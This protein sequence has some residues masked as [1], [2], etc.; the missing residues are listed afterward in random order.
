MKVCAF[1]SKKKCAVLVNGNCEKCSFCKTRRELEEGRRS[2]KARIRSLPRYER[3]YIEEKYY[4]SK[5]GIK[6]D[7][8]RFGIE[9]IF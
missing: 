9:C 3:E 8:S 7:L 5:I 1:K 2:S 6:S 4:S